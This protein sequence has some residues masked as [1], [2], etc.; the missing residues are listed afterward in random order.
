M[1]ADEIRLL[2]AYNRWAN[3]RTLA[4]AAVLTPEQLHRDLATS[5]GSVFGTMVHILWGEWRW[6]GRWMAA[7]TAPAPAA[8]PAASAAAPPHSPPPAT[9]APAASPSPTANVPVP[10]VPTA[11]EPPYYCQYYGRPKKGQGSLTL[12]QTEVFTSGT[13]QATI[14]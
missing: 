12:Y 2:Y 7:A 6:L 13:P 9:P 14:N 1:E 8:T 3:A 11:E 10:S 4:A 5:H